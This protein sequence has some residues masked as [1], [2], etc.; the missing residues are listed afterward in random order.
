MQSKISTPSTSIVE[1][2]IYLASLA[3]QPKDIDPILDEVRMVTSR[4]KPGQA[5]AGQDMALMQSV[6]SR[7]EDYL[8]HKDQ[9]SSFTKDSLQERIKNHFDEQRPYRILLRAAKIVG[10]TIFIIFG[11]LFS[12]GKLLEAPGAAVFANVFGA[13]GA[14]F[15]AHELEVLAGLFAVGAVTFWTA[16][17]SRSTPQIRLSYL[18]FSFTAVLL[19]AAPILSSRWQ[20]VLQAIAICAAFVALRRVG[21][22]FNVVLSGLPGGATNYIVATGFVTAAA[23]YSPIG[24]LLTLALATVSI[25][26]G[27]RILKLVNAA[28]A[29]ALKGLLAALGLAGVVALLYLFH[30]SNT[31]VT[32]V[33]G[34]T[35]L[36]NSFLFLV[37]AYYFNRAARF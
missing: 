8:L 37:S 9:L 5:L 6:Q 17:L 19:G 1:V 21:A 7:L 10:A 32:S 20:G 28:Y 22:Q 12:I 3:S 16:S 34:V 26:Q 4:L 11:G 13:I 25:F 18:L 29:N 35:L 2:V 27:S 30:S 23:L 24:L 15:S 33:V 14:V 31:D 36:V